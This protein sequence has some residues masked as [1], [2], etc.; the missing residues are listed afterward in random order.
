MLDAHELGRW[1]HRDNAHERRQ[2]YLD[3][4]GKE[5]HVALQVELDD[6]GRGRGEQLGQHAPAR[7]GGIDAVGHPQRD[8]EDAHFEH[9]A[10]LVPSDLHRPREGYASPRLPRAV[11]RGRCPLRPAGLPRAVCRRRPNREPGP[12]RY[13]CL[14]S[15]PCRS[16]PSGRSARGEPEG[17]SPVSSPRRR[18]PASSAA[19]R[20]ACVGGE[21]VLVNSSQQQNLISHRYTQINTDKFNSQSLDPFSH[22]NILKHTE[23]TRSKNNQVANRIISGFF[24]VRVFRVIPWPIWPLISSVPICVYLWL[25]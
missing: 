11:L 6:H 23:P 8:V 1:R 10:R 22:E 24:S 18:S 20:Q 7:A 19:S 12:D 4:I 13:S 3:V 21:P 5:A 2:R 14:D 9:I 25:R 16:S 17:G 15:R